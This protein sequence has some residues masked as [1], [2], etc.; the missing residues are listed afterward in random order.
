[1][2]DFI[3]NVRRNVPEFLDSLYKHNG[4]FSWSLNNDLYSSKEKWG[5]AN[6]VFA[7]KL[8]YILGMLE[9]IPLKRKNEIISFIKN[10][11]KKNGSI[12]DP[13]VYKKISL[14]NKLVSIKH[15][16][17]SNFFSQKTIMAETR[18]ALV[19]LSLFDNR[20]NNPYIN[21]PYSQT[22]LEKYIKTLHWKNVWGA[23]SHVSHEV[24]FLQYNAKIFDFKINESQTLINLCLDKINR[25]QNQNDGMWYFLQVSTKQKIN[26]AMKI[27][28]TY[29]L[30]EDNKIPYADKVIDFVLESEK[31]NYYFDGCDNLNA[32]FVLK[33]AYD[34]C[35]KNYRSDDVKNFGERS[36]KRFE[37]YF[38]T[39]EGGFSFLPSAYKRNFYGLQ[40]TDSFQ[41]PDIHGTFLLTWAVALASS[42]LDIK[43]DFQPDILN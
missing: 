21:I 28:T 13:L 36:I 40:I 17:F 10:F 1:M 16:N 35:D 15:F 29:N 25:I 3:S 7:V 14:L 4:F 19:A 42:V 9:Q 33:Y 30:L 32:I 8:Y 43:N 31:E 26:A 6:A 27:I 24:F 39:Q 22:K 38:F 18:Q 41:G 5:L 11:E 34:S 20:S 2:N 23:A 12:N 37:K